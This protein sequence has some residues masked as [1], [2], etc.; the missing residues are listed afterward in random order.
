LQGRN[1]EMVRRPFFARY[2]A[3]ASW[4]DELEPLT[5][6]DAKFWPGNWDSDSL[7]EEGIQ[8]TV[9]SSDE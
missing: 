4:F 7:S 5:E 1:P 8:L 6:A 9:S 3:T 2:S